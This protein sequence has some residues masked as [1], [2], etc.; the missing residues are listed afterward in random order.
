MY[1]INKKELHQCID[2]LKYSEQDKINY[3]IQQSFKS[4][5]DELCQYSEDVNKSII[6]KCVSNDSSHM[7]GAVYVSLVDKNDE[8]K[9]KQYKNAGMSPMAD[10]DEPA[11]DFHLPPI[12]ESQ[13]LYR[14]IF[15][16]AE[17]D[18]LKNFQNDAAELRKYT[19]KYS[20]NGAEHTFTYHLVFDRTFVEKHEL[21]YQ[22]ASYFDFVNPVVFSPYSYKSFLVVYPK[23][24]A[25]ENL[26][27]CFSKNGIDVIA[28][29]Y[30]MYWNFMIRET[31][32]ITYDTKIPYGDDVKYT[33]VFEKNRHGHY[34]LPLPID[35]DVLIYDIRV[36]CDSVEISIS[37]GTCCFRVLEYASIDKSFFDED[38]KVRKVFCNSLD[39][40]FSGFRNKRIISDADIEHAIAPYRRNETWLNA[41]ISNGCEHEHIVKRYSAQFRPDLKGKR[42]FKKTDTVHLKFNSKSALNFADD[43]INYVLQYLEWFYPEIEWAGEK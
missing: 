23:S 3:E 29:N 10:I 22:Y 26:D 1:E 28:D 13:Y 12:S 40:T 21:L 8:M 14:R 11:N 7:I 16:N 37:S 5:F 27:F 39:E 25:D 17:Y 38:V 4:L 15:V 2:K 18:K 36:N 34:C 31:E 19:G 30:E 41:E 6:D 35:K 42:I 32:V 43:Y 24:L 33:Y 9:L 20:T